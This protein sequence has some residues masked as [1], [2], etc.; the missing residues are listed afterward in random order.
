MS[1]GL[2]ALVLFLIIANQALTIFV[3]SYPVGTSSMNLTN[4]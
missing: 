3:F 1:F 4:I 2:T